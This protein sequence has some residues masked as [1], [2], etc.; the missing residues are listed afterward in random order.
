MMNL[1]VFTFLFYCSIFFCKLK[2]R[3]EFLTVNKSSENLQKKTADDR[4]A[5]NLLQTIFEAGVTPEFA[6]NPEDA[7]A[8]KCGFEFLNAF[9]YLQ[10]IVLL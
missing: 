9:I 4:R 5:K 1:K 10:N 6:E 2:K 3:N 8:L 7:D